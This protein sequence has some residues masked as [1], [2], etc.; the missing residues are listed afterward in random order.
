M[1]NLCD[2][3]ILGGKN[4]FVVLDISSCAFALGVVVPIPT[5][6]NVKRGLKSSTYTFSKLVEE[7]N[8]QQQSIIDLERDNQLLVGR[9]SDKLAQ[10][11]N[12]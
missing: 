12:S 2:S 4:P 11:A 10:E 8:A 3:F 1:A 9:L 7:N 5:C 6:A